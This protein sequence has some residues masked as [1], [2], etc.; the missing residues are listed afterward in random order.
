MSYKINDL[1][2]NG[3]KDKMYNFPSDKEGIDIGCEYQLIDSFVGIDASFTIYLMKRKYLPMFLKRWIYNKTCTKD[4]ISLNKFL[5][6]LKTKTIIHHDINNGIPFEDSTTKNIFTSHFIEH[7][8]KEQGENILKECY[9]VL[10][11]EGILRIVCPSVDEEINTIEEDILNYKKSR[12]PEVIQKYLT[13][14]SFGFKYH[15]RFAFH[16]HLYNFEEL[17]RILLK[18]GFREVI[19]QEF[20]KGK[21]VSVEKLDK[22]N[23]LIVEAIR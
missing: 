10:K 19:E 6:I 18:I 17:K 22:R 14:E 9:R 20:R 15:N 13:K 12:N 3:K 4:W 8:T 7:L 1:I 23:G 16:R 11:K 2:L 21:I 5:N